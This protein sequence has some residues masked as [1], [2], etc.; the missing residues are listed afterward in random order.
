[1]SQNVAAEG[2]DESVLNELQNIWEMKLLESR[3]LEPPL[4]FSKD[5]LS[6]SYVF[7]YNGPRNIVVSPS[8]ISSSHNEHEIDEG[9]E[10]V[11]EEEE[12]EGAAVDGSMDHRTVKKSKQILSIREHIENEKRK[13][14]R[15]GNDKWDCNQVDGPSAVD[16]EDYDDKGENEEE[17][18]A[19][20]QKLEIFN[21]SEEEDDEHDQEQTEQVGDFVLCQYEKVTRTKNKWR[22]VL[23][24]VIMHLRGKDYVFN[25][26]HGEFEW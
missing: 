23:K 9:H 13:M 17:K 16:E 10:E 6:K 4:E 18:L 3:V 22:C 21:L 2:I 8:T 12:E 25:R 14:A 15:S 1:M 24:D 7:H 19:K 26:A 11:E 20:R 5:T